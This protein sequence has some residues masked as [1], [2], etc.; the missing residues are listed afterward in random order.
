MKI[1]QPFNKCS[2][3]LQSS[4]IDITTAVGLLKSLQTVIQTIRENFD[5]YEKKEQLKQATTTTSPVSHERGRKN[6]MMRHQ[7]ISLTG[8]HLELKHL[9]PSLTI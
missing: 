2:I 3:N 7:M 4:L 1:P 9:S 5:A 6:M 8:K